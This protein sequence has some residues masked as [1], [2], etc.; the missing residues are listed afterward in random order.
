M[1]KFSGRIFLFLLVCL[2]ANL[3]QAAILP[4]PAG[5]R[6]GINYLAGNTSVTLVLHAPG[7]TRAFVIGEFNGWAQNTSTQM[8]QTPDRQKFWLTITNLTP[9]V[10]YGFQYV[11]DNIR[12]ADPYCEKILDP[13][14]DAS[15]N[16][17]SG[18][19]VYANLKPY[20]TGRTTG[21]VGV[22]QT[23]KPVFNWAVPNFNRPDQR[24]LLVYELLV[25][26]FVATH[27]WKTL[28]DTLGYLQRLGINA[29]ELMPFNEFD[30]NN[31]WGYNPNFYNAPDKYY[32]TD[33]D[34]NR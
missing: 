18:F 16:D 29:I 22:L 23:A 26:D 11:V 14:H 34:L 5:T 10:E 25:R 33:T 12:I 13:T 19:T 17:V 6:D 2:H 21:Y 4:L 28:R 1:K 32:G 20:P 7:K 9:G 3:L 8:H 27:S 30:A 24:R 15:I 31:S